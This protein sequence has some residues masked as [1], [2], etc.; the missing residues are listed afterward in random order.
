VLKSDCQ[1]IVPSLLYIVVNMFAPSPPTY[2]LPIVTN[3]L[4]ELVKLHDHSR[5]IGL[6][7]EVCHSLF[8]CI[9]A[10]AIEFKQSSRL[11]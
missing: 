4:F 6:P 11:I 10:F 7:V 1:S 8:I 3:W 5:P 2:E 9:C